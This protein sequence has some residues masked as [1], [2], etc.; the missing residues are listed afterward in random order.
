[1]IYRFTREKISPVKSCKNIV[2][3]KND[4]RV[5]SF[6]FSFS[7]FSGRPLS[8]SDK[9]ENEFANERKKRRSFQGSFE[10]E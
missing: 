9:I 6:S 4:H 7:L 10:T 8:M 2:V 3:K 1:M 5:L